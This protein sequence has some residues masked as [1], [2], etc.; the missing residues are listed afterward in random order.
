MAKYHKRD[1][2]C[3]E[4]KAESYKFQRPRPLSNVDFNLCGDAWK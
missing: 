3:G 4:W 1:Q 2:E